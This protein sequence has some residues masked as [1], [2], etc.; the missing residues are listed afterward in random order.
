M[1][2]TSKTLQAYLYNVSFIFSFH[3]LQG[4]F[5]N[6]NCPSHNNTLLRASRALTFRWVN[7][8]QI[9]VMGL[10]EEDALHLFKMQP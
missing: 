8:L 5:R 6:V 10:V 1:I 2:L 3:N 9:Q 7:Y 4:Y